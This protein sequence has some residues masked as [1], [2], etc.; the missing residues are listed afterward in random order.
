MTNRNKIYA[1]VFGVTRGYTCTKGS[2]PETEERLCQLYYNG[3]KGTKM[4]VRKQNDGT[5]V[6]SYLVYP[7]KNQF[8]LDVEGRSGSFFGMSV[9]MEK[10]YTEHPSKLFKMFE[11]L[12]NNHIK[13]KLIKEDNN[14]NKQWL[15]RDLNAADVKKYIHSALNKE[16]GALPEISKDVKPSIIQPQLGKNHII[17]I[18]QVDMFN[19]S[20]MNSQYGMTVVKEG[21]VRP[22]KSQNK[23]QITPQ[24]KSR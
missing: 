5:V 15:V 1:H 9:I 7:E 22:L 16:Y 19:A 18:S 6:Y 21:F 23:T 20:I 13:N 4:K 10:Q 3:D 8:F 11:N 2:A 12:Y 24:L 17:N 14:G